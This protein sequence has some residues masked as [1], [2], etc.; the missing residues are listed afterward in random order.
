MTGGSS[1][2]TRGLPSRKWRAAAVPVDHP[3]T[4]GVYGRGGLPGCGGPGSSPHTRGLLQGLWADYQPT[5]IIPA[6]AGF[7]APD[8]GRDHLR[9][10]HPRTRGVYAHRARALIV[11]AG[12]SPHTRGLLVRLVDVL[13]DRGII[14]AHAG[15]TSSPLTPTYQA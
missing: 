1:P 3:R 5:G 14:P 12:S 7:T 10:D 4:R 15:F 9:G 11:L 8:E 6:H 2:H 13:P